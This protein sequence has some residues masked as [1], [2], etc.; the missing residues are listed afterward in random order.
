MVYREDILPTVL[1]QTEW[2]AQRR[3]FDLNRCHEAPTVAGDKDILAPPLPWESCHNSGSR[4]WDGGNNFRISRSRTSGFVKVV[5]H[6]A[7]QCIGLSY[8]YRS[9]S[10]SPTMRHPCGWL[11]PRLICKPRPSL[12]LRLPDTTMPALLLCPNR[13]VNMHQNALCSQNLSQ[14]Y[15]QKAKRSY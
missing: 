2:Q 13:I 3:S 6:S 12:K 14:Q 11:C 10:F 15:T 8:T 4:S 9:V 7:T 1:L 5:V